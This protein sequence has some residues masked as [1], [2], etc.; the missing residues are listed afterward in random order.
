M[1]G[2]S[3][4]VLLF[5]TNTAEVDYVSIAETN[6]KLI[7]RYLGLPTTIVQG[8]VGTNKR[9]VSGAVVEWNNGGRC[10]AYELSPYDQTLVLDSDY[11]IFDNNL[12]K[13]LDTVVDYAIPNKNV[14]IN[15]ANTIDT[16]GQYSVGPM[17][18][19]TA[20]AFNRTE[21][22][23]QLFQL[24]KMIQH[25]YG[26]YR[27]LYNI[28]PANFRNDVAFTIADRIVNG[29]VDN[30]ENR[31]PWPVVTVSGKVSNLTLDNTA[32]RIIAYTDTEAFIVPWNSLHL[33][34]K[35]V[36]QSDDFKKAVAHVVA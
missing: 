25:N 17:L 18:W 15:S 22:S 20:I 13:V 3:K 36:L 12:L 4:G 23:K 28:S 34:D 31:I 33:H 19:A 30:I 7:D 10:N 2:K 6:A 16:M 14:Y 32:R 1:P 9:L 26:Y 21:K 29:Y 11:L 5:A 24:V 8:D 27:A 35:T